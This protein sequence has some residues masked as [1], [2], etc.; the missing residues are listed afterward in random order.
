MKHTEFVHL[1][2]H[3][4]Y[5]ILESTIRLEDL[6]AK[7]A[8]YKMPAVAMTDDSVFF[9]MVPFFNQ[10]KSKGV[11]PILGAE[12][13]VA[14]KSMA[15]RTPSRIPNESFNLVLLVR[16]DIGYRNL[17]KMITLA[18]FEGF[19]IKPRIDKDLLQKH[20]EGLICLSGNMDGEISCLLLQNK[21]LEAE[22]LGRFY[23]ELFGKGHFF[24][25]IQDHGL[26]Q[27]KILIPKILQLAKTLGVDVVATN[28]CHYFS[29]DDSFAHD[30]ARC[31]SMGVTL[32]DPHPTYETTEYHYKSYEEMQE[33]FHEHPEVLSNTV[34]VAEL[35]NFAPDF[36]SYHLPEYPVPEGK[37]RED[38][39]MDLCRE[40]MKKK[41]DPDSPVIQERLAHEFKIIKQMGFVSY[42]LIVWDFVNYSKKNKIPVGPG[43]GSAAGSLIAYLLGITSINPMKY[44]LL[45]ERFLNPARISMPDIDM[46]FC[47]DRRTEV[48][49]YVSQKY[50]RNSVAQIITYGTL[51]ARAVIRDVGRVMGMPYPKV[52]Q[53][54]KLIPGEPKMTLE[55]AIQTEPQLT[56]LM[57]EDK[58]IEA[59]F[60]NAKK[61]EGLP[62]NTSTHAAGIIISKGDLTDKVPL[63]KGQE[64]E[65][66]TQF[67]GPS[68]EK[69]GLLK[70][71]FLGLKTL[72]VL[73]MAFKMANEQKGSPILEDLNDIPVDDPK[74]YDLL[75]KG[76]TLGVFQLESTGMRDLMRR[77]EVKD[78][79]DIVALVALYRPGPLQMA[80]DFIQRKHGKVKVEYFHPC[81]KE[82]LQ[83]TYGVMLYQ[84]Q[85]M[86]CAQVMGNFS[87]AEADNLR[88]IMGKKKEEEMKL[89]KDKFISGSAT[90]KI[91]HDIAEKTFE[92]MEYF[93][94]YGFNKSHSVAYG[95]IAYQ[96]A[97]FKANYPKEFM[98]ALL[99]SEKNDID[100][101]GFYIEECKNIGLE[102][103]P[104]SIQYSD[105]YFTV[106]KDGMI[107]GLA[108]IKNVG[109]AVAKVIVEK[110]KISGPYQNLEDFAKRMDARVLNK[111]AL[112]NLIK[113]GAFDSLEKNRAYLFEIVDDITRFGTGSQRDSAAGQGSFLDVLDSSSKQNISQKKK[114][115]YP[116]WPEH[117][118]LKYE[119]E[120]LG[121]YIS[122]H[123]L[124]QYSKVL[125]RFSSANTKDLFNLKQGA[126]IKIGG[127]ITH[128]KYT[129]TQKDE[130]PMAIIQIEDLVGSVEAVLYPKT[131]AHFETLLQMDALIFL[132]GSLQFRNEIPSLITD[133]IVP[134]DKVQEELTTAVYIRL[135]ESQNLEIF[136]KLKMVFESN[137][138]PCKLFLD[139]DLDSGKTILLKLPPKYSIHPAE[140]IIQSIEK[141]TGED[142][143]WLHIKDKEKQKF[144]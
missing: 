72:T 84:E 73:D 87:L 39:L 7:T 140:K 23:L 126:S 62:R 38:Y 58:E 116:N 128:I 98:A 11:K 63:Y 25:E 132:K 43:R 112:E 77:L 86:K 50:G 70:M 4:E 78:F 111:K 102:V 138:G 17:S 52:D 51:A 56:A 49:E 139:L 35:C 117:E 18:Q 33:L 31:I 32:N 61:L 131:F 65:I 64:N 121:F 88:K 104:P 37:T 29:R 103:K 30:I 14:P 89:Q 48:I 68:C 79:S 122:G 80:D 60:N 99:T 24:L 141:L 21:M 67:D 108:A 118:L 13:H 110:R 42:F 133:D 57:D 66:I 125:K 114:E 55:K 76:N 12:V 83:E 130:K 75:T 127:I 109:A 143:V 41:V 144:K 137:P 34:K 85:V 134:L 119:K 123:P 45:F 59:L 94:G 54:A 74:T 6:I 82:I 53:I 93:A 101:I 142:S 20:A 96:T 136:E 115:A 135:T 26:K 113:A 2:V 97:W 120:L 8:E 5:S 92:A 16:N 100:K 44:D 3:T 22:K 105:E 81:L 1:H 28:D 90:L 27:E 69:I 129:K 10:C 36:K 47:Y 106:D 91:P 46:D 95:W 9:G 19:F 107:F 124:G 40:G 71:D 15:D